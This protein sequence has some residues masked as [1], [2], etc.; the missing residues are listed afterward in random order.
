MRGG[1]WGRGVQPG[2]PGTARL[3]PGTQG[4]KPPKKNNRTRLASALILVLAALPATGL[5]PPFPGSAASRSG[6][7]IKVFCRSAHFQPISHEEA[8]WFRWCMETC[9]LSCLGLASGALTRG[10]HFLDGDF[11]PHRS[12]LVS[13]AGLSS[14]SGC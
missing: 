14:V 7:L 8:R 2:V 4:A 6:L 11:R 1:A 10:K 3:R 12:N 9:A 5:D 13:K